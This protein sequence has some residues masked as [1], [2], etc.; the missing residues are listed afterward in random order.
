MQRGRDGAMT[1]N[2]MSRMNPMAA[3]GFAIIGRIPTRSACRP[4]DKAG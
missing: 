2:W 4:Q 1:V 3:D